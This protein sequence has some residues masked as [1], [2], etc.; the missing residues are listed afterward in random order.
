MRKPIRWLGAYR[1]SHS[2]LVTSLIW[3][4][5]QEEQKPHKRW[6]AGK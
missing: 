3:E 1:N 6:L 5:T 2:D 4:V